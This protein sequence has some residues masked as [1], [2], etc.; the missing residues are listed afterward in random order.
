MIDSGDIF[1]VGHLRCLLFGGND[2][3]LV[4]EERKMTNG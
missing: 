3:V 1:S 4:E 2:I